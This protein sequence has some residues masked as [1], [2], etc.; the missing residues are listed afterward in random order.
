MAVAINNGV[1]YNND[2]PWVDHYILNTELSNVY[3]LYMNEFNVIAVSS[4]GQVM[5]VNPMILDDNGIGRYYLAVTA[6][7]LWLDGITTGCSQE[8]LCSVLDNVVSLLN[9]PTLLS[10]QAQ[11]N[12]KLDIMESGIRQVLVNVVEEV[13][14]N[15]TIIQS[16]TG[17]TFKVMI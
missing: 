5:E 7:V 2:D 6:D 15:Q 11:I 13:N 12:S 10:A 1:V 17:H 4:V 8:K 16:S 3:R 9:N 14:E